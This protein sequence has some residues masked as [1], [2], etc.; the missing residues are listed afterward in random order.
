MKKVF[1]YIKNNFYIII[2][3]L[4]IGII[5]GVVVNNKI[6][7]IYISIII[8]TIVFV[9]FIYLI[10]KWYIHHIANSTLKFNRKDKYIDPGYIKGTDKM[11]DSIIELDI[12]LIDFLDKYSSGKKSDY[13]E[14]ELNKQWKMHSKEFTEEADRI[15]SKM[16]NEQLL[17]SLLSTEQICHIVDIF[18]YFKPFMINIDFLIKNPE[19]LPEAYYATIA[20]YNNLKEMSINSDYFEKLK[21]QNYFNKIEY[22]I[23]S[24]MSNEQLMDLATKSND[25][26]EKLYL[27]GYLNK[28]D[29]K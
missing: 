7:N 16:N 15:F 21:D 9:V 26:L 13:K 1:K 28:D 8:G 10:N 12:K 19:H 27:Y 18:S 29:K 2:I 3:D 25:W 24:N 22:F 17:L 4:V 11:L 20:N 23:L 14:K 5:T 6:K